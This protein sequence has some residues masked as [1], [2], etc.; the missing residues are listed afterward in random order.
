MI[1]I[2]LTLFTIAEMSERSIPPIRSRK[3]AADGL[4]TLFV[5]FPYSSSIFS[6]L[7]FTALSFSA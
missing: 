2:E 6:M 7:V 4:T 5:Y 3:Y 1:S